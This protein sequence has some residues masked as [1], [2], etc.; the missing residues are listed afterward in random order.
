MRKQ[1]KIF[2]WPVY[3][4]SNKTRKEG[5]RVPKKSATPSPK[6]HE[7][8]LAAE[9]TGNQPEILPDASYPRAPLEKT[10]VVTVPKK[11]TKGKIL[12]KIAKELSVARR[13]KKASK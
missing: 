4:D 7:I 9:R 3:F 11:D 6:L 2:L 5:R 12:R 13:K 10:G 1:N 8:Q